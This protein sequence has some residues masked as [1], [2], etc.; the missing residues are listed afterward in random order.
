MDSRINKEIIYINSDNCT[1]CNKCI[2]KCPINYANISYLNNDERK[3]KIEPSRCLHCGHCIETC[4]HKARDY[5]DD[6]ES[7]FEDLSKGFKISIIAA[8]SLKFNFNN[9]KKLFGFLKSKGVN[10]VYDVSYGADISVWAYLKVVK[11]K[12]IESTIA[13][14]CPVVVN[15]IEK[16]RPELIPRLIPVHSPSLCT[17][18]YLRKYR[19]ID[20]KI[21]F[22]SPCIGKIDEFNDRNTDNNI[23]YNV[24]YRKLLEYLCNNNIDLDSYNEYDFDSIDTGLGLVFSRPGGLKENIEFYSNDLWVRQIEGHEAAYEYLDKYSKKVD[25]GN[26]LPNIIDILNCSQGCNLG[27]AAC[28]NM[29][30]DYINY[31][32]NE[33]KNAK[34]NNLQ[35]NQSDLLLEA[36]DK[37]LSIND[38]IRT[39]S[40]KSGFIKKIVQPTEEEYEKIFN[41]LYKFTEESRN[42]NCFTC[43]Y[44]SCRNFAKAIYNGLDTPISC[45]H[46]TRQ[47][48]MEFL[49]EKEI[50]ESANKAKSE[51]LANMSHEIR[52][53]MNGVIGFINLLL[54]T[55]LDE[56]Q[57]D[58][59]DEAKKSS[60][61]LLTIINDILDFSKIEAGKMSMEIIK[62]NIRSVVEDVAVL[63]MSNAHKKGLEVNAL[64]HSDVPQKLCGDPGRL[65]QVLNNFLS[66]SI[67]FTHQGEVLITVKQEDET[68]DSITLKFEVSDTGIG[69]PKDKLNKIFESF[70]QA[71]A[72]TTR[73]FGG[74]GLGLAISKRIVEMMNGNISVTSEEGE[75]SIFTCTAKFKKCLDLEPIKPDIKVLH[76]VNVLIIDDNST[77]TKVAGYY[78]KESGCNV[79]ELS[80]TESAISMLKSGLHI[81]IIILDYLMPDMD[82]MTIASKIK[83]IPEFKYIPLVLITSHAHRG[84]A[85]AAKETGFKGYLTKPIRKN[86]LLECVTL[87]LEVKPEQDN[88]N[89]N[90]LITKHSIKEN[91]FNNKF[92]ILLVED[93]KTNQKLTTKI[94][95]KADFICDIT[96]NGAEAIEAYKNKSY[97]LILMDCQMPVLD[98]YEATKE[99][100]NIENS[101][102]M[103]EGNIKHI[104]IIALTAHSMD[105]DIDK[106]LSYGM[107][108]YI[109]KPIDNKKLI[110]TVKKHLPIESLFNNQEKKLTLISSILSEI[111]RYTGFSNDEAKEF[112]DDYLKEIPLMVENI[113]KAVSE[114][115]SNLIASYAHS[116]KGSSANLRIYELNELALKLENAAKSDDILLCDILLKEI[117][118]YY[119]LLSV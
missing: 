90:V 84:D 42:I 73:R 109:S 62:F 31:Q 65:K 95:S 28:K 18:I 27:S 46:Y 55:S 38:F 61:S 82:R 85:K 93:N 69:I 76:N 106:C 118:D 83:D 91:L 96:S 52:T 103:V 66:N 39:Y 77:N 6:T 87:A 44:G 50:A 36:F 57:K 25:N 72:S 49:K 19:N 2:L 116:M 30:D 119:N 26:K 112:L 37:E 20:E 107:D 105:G 48:E 21:A 51:F 70:A 100:R 4:D 74:T 56:E 17:A 67:K 10:I 88:L 115:D 60:E 54:D 80:H 97:D 63:A 15:Y 58:F 71:D 79:Y 89:E 12:D 34:I 13:Q 45:I 104:P 16:Y 108:D 99:I 14:P 64:I 43:G 75:G 117:Q 86:D 40:D 33:L 24:T 35:D 101:K 1:G 111:A 92:K 78:L 110:E 98:G 3:I 9:Y 7:F 29:D 11:E 8:P 32:M 81:D 23:Q 53:P 114:H 59:V 102:G 41:E 22:L 47:I 68:D 94:L 113:L 5:Y